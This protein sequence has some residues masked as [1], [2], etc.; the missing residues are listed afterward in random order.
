MDPIEALSF[1]F[2]LGSLELGR[3]RQI[4]SSPANSAFRLIFLRL[5][6]LLVRVL[7]AHSADDA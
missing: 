2:M 6:G 5:T 4:H 3:V 7:D 1:L